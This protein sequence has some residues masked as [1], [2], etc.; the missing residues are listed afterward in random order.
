M[1]LSGIS[2]PSMV[3][4]IPFINDFTYIYKYIKIYMESHDPLQIQN[5]RVKDGI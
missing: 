4:V 2:P 1:D 5:K 3:K